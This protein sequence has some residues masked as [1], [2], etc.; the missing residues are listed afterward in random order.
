VLFIVF[1]AETHALPRSLGCLLISLILATLAPTPSV[2]QDAGISSRHNPWAR[3]QIGAWKLVRVSTETL[4]DA[5]RVISTNVTETR[6]SL[7]RVDADGVVLE[8]EVGV[9]IA[10]KQFTGLPQCVKQGFHGELTGG[11]LTVH[12]STTAEVTIEDHKFPCRSQQLE[13]GNSSSRTAINLCYSDS[14]APFILRRQSKTSDAANNVL[15][16]TLSEVVALDMPQRVLSEIKN[17]SC[18]KTVQKTPKGTVT[19]LAMS[20]A[21]VPGG[22][23]NQTSKELDP[24]GRLIRRSTL[25]LLSYGIHAEKERIGLFGRKRTVRVRKSTY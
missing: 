19:T 11:E 13:L 25:E 9:E 12:P 23:V 21:D 24:A 7:T 22:V 15:S 20:S 2:G 18:I 17:V 6:T 5:G 10:G 1:P 16:E 8:V 4:D 3:F 14:L